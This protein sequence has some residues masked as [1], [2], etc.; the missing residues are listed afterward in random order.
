MIKQILFALVLAATLV[1]PVRADRVDDY[2]GAQME[3][4]HLPGLCLAVI[5]EGKT[6]KTQGYGLANLELSVPVT[7]ET[8]FEIGS[9]TKQFTA[10]CIMMLV[11]S[12]KIALDDPLGKYLDIP[13]S[14]KTITV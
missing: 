14:W 4:R 8:V 10:V 13:E 6:I 9:L 5:R 11:E 2:L 1:A 3:R 7:P 12:R